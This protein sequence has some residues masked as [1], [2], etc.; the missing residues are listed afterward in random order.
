MYRIK[1]STVLTINE[2]FRSKLVQIF[3]NTNIN[4]GIVYRNYK[5]KYMQLSE[6]F[7]KTYIQKISWEN[8]N[9]FINRFLKL[10]PLLILAR[11][12]GKSPVEYFNKKQKN[13]ARLLAL[14]ILNENPKSINNFFSIWQND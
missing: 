2:R 11:L 3:K 8:K 12:D 6:K 14:K 5:D 7:I 4:L 1:K 13:N 10:L 9:N